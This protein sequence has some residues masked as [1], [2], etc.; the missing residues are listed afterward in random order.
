LRPGT[1][2]LLAQLDRIAQFPLHQQQAHVHA[3]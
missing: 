3:H 2:E 1:T